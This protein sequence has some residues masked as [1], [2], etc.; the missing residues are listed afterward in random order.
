[1]PQNWS[2]LTRPIFTPAIILLM[3]ESTNVYNLQSNVYNEV[4]KHKGGTKLSISSAFTGAFTAYRTE[5][6][7]CK[8][9]EI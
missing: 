2:E 9:S 7:E 1:M 3:T 6:F 5:Q 8:K 4:N